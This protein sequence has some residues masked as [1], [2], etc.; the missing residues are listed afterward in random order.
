MKRPSRPPNDPKPRPDRPRPGATQASTK[1]LS[2]QRL[3]QENSQYADTAGVSANNSHLN[4][5]PAFRDTR[6]GRVEIARFQD[7]RPA[8][9]HLLCALPER[10]VTQRDANGQVSAVHCRIEAGFVRN[11]VFFTREQLAQ[12]R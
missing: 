5:Q 9:I 12:E 8:P 1:D 7:G 11:G 3:A 2:D 6:S 4:Y 10:W